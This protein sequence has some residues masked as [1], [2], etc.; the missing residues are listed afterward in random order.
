MA[1]SVFQQALQAHVSGDGRAAESLYLRAIKKRDN[2]TAAV[3][4]LARLYGD[5]RVD[6]CSVPYSVQPVTMVVK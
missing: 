5:S 2:E 1:N 6:S 4:N 3:L